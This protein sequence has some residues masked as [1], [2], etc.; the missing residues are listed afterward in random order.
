MTMDVN[1]IE[2]SYDS[3]SKI[4]RKTSASFKTINVFRATLIFFHYGYIRKTLLVFEKYQIYL[5]YLEKEQKK[6]ASM[7]LV[8]LSYLH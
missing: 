7:L 1:D 2:N 5:Q 4:K 3:H 6:K 8:C